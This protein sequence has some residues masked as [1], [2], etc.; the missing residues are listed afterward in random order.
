MHLTVLKMVVLKNNFGLKLTL[1]NFTRLSNMLSV[2][3]Q[4]VGKH[5]QK[6]PKK[7]SCENSMIPSCVPNELK[8][9]TQVEEMLIARALPIMRVY[10]KP[11]GQRGW[12]FRALY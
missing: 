6:S 12:L 7:F 9:L 1:T 2:N 11:G 8:S 10:I 3:V 4:Y 5:G